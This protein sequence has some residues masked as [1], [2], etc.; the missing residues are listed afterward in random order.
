MPDSNPLADQ[1]LEPLPGLETP[2]AAGMDIEGVGTGV[3]GGA[4]DALSRP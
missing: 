3:A 1:F 4:T 2:T